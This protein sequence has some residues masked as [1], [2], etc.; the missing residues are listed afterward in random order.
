MAT[1]AAEVSGID[2][3]SDTPLVVDPS[4]RNSITFRKLR[5]RS[6]A[7]FRSNVLPFYYPLFERGSRTE[8]PSQSIVAPHG[9]DRATRALNIIVGVVGLLLTTPLFLLIAI[10]IKLT[11]RGP[12]FYKQTRI[13]LDRRWNR[14][15]THEDSRIRDLGGHPFTMYKFRTM[16]VAAESD[17]K[18][19]WAR[20][21][22]ERVT[23]I[24][25]RLRV[26]RL[27][28][29]PQLLNVLTGDMNIVGPRPERPTIFAELREAIP[30]YHMRQRV[31]PGITGWAQVNQ[32]Y[33][34]SVDD[35]RRKVQFDLEYLSTRSVTR[36]LRIMARTVPIMLFSR[37]GW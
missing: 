25:R 12:V 27:D 11:S 16:V 23:T 1:T 15:P 5:S 10:A 28:E 14:A 3:D 29:L 13:G 36:D 9:S 32:A 30:D 33:D 37:L 31:M 8:G 18:E 24:G 20:P 34:T 19:V 22:D 17:S 26:T 21:D 6:H 2:S 4:S 35:V 7:L